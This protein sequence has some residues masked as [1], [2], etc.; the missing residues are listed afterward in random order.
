MNYTGVVKI[1]KKHDKSLPH[2]KG[3]FKALTQP[4]S[5]CG[6][7]NVVEQ[8]AQR[9]EKKYANWFCDG[10]MREAYAQLLPKK[11]DGLDTD[12]SQLR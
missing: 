11:G 7:G 4:S 5:I 2:R 8:L 10:N 3:H 9:I 12:W 6:E 1:V